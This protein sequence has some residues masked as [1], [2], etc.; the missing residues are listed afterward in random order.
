MKKSA[1][2]L[3]T[4]AFAVAVFAQSANA[5]TI[6]ISGTFAGTGGGGSGSTFTE[7]FAGLGSDTTFG[8]FTA[9]ETGT[10]NID[11]GGNVS[12]AG[13]FS[14]TFDAGGLMSGTFTGSGSGGPLSIL[15]SITG[16]LLAGDTGQAT[17]TAMFDPINNTISGSYKGSISGPGPELGLING[18]TVTPAETPLPAALPMFAG[19]AGLIGFMARRRKRKAL[20]V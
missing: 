12:V 16:G 1:L 18:L 14:F 15:F 11:G 8:N 6:P 13:P 9:S 19:G 2:F 20:T 3:S 7:T 5:V 4:A 10:V 17:G